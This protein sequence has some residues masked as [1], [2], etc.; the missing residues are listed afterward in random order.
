M[1]LTEWENIMPGGTK[2][3]LAGPEFEPSDNSPEC[4]DWRLRVWDIAAL[5]AEHPE[6]EGRTIAR[7][8]D[9]PGQ[10]RGHDVFVL[11]LA[12]P[13]PALTVPGFAFVP[14]ALASLHL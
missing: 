7:I 12:P 6:L 10:F 13:K 2:V 5:V 14:D 8:T 3:L 4:C 1:K 9:A 11:W